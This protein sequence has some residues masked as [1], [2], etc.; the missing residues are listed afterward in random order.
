MDEVALGFDEFR[1][2]YLRDL[3]EAPNSVQ[4]LINKLHIHTPLSGAG[5]VSCELDVQT[6]ILDRKFKI[7]SLRLSLVFVKTEANGW[8]NI[9]IYRS[10]HRLTTKTKPIQS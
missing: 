4:Y 9:C 7:N 6:Q 3:S 5:I 2:L 1:K 8:R 10:P